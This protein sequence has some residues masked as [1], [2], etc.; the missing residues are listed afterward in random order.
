MI[1]PTK[2]ARLALFVGSVVALSGCGPKTAPPLEPG[3]MRGSPPD[4]RGRRVVLLPVQQVY[5]VL[6][7]PDAELAF[8]LGDRGRDVEWV[9][10]D[11]VQRVLTRSP[12]VDTRT[13]GLPVGQFTMVEVRR[14]GDPLYGQLRRIAALVDADAVLLPVAATFEP[15]ESVAGSGPRVRMTLALI[16][17]RTGQVV[18]FGVE[19]GGEYERDDP[20]ALASVVDRVARTLFWYVSDGNQEG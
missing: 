4:L 9:K 14:I 20:R 18:W 19:E 12:G 5:G 6:G 1:M 3:Q 11:E 2:T 10:E 7:D 13:R 16:E 15:N 8:A 17:P